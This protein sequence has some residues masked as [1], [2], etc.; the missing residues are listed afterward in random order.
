MSIQT[1]RSDTS[2][3]HRDICSEKLKILLN[4]RNDLAICFDELLNDC[5]NGLRHFKQYKQFKMYN[6]PNLNPQMYSEK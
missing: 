1:K 2:Q 3:T 5:V 6:D 4:Q